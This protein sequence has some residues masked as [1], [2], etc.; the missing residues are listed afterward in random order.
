MFGFVRPA[1]PLIVLSFGSYGILN[2]KNE[3]HDAKQ[4]KRKDFKAAIGDTPLLYLKSLSEAT[5]REIYAK[6]EF[7]NPTGSV[8]DRAAKGKSNSGR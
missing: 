5:G 7:M 8:K 2:A 4:M 1:V 6:A 3:P